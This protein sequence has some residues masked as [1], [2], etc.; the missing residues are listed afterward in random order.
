MT[1]IYSKIQRSKPN[2]KSAAKKWYPVLKTLGALT[3]KEVA[4]RISND[5]TLNPKEAD[6]ALYR[7]EKVLTE[8]LLEGRTVKIGDWGTFRLTCNS[9]PS[10]TKEEA[11]AKKIT[12]LNLRF[13]PGS[14]V[15][16]ALKTATF[17]SAESLVTEEKGAVDGG[18]DSTP[19]DEVIS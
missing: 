3:N 7:L 18:G 4:E 9:L 12:R 17:M 6:M 13:I 8:A 15:R 10:D 2:D 16:N 5:T 14:T 11:N 19:D 1:L